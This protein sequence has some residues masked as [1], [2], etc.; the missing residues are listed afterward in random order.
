MTEAEPIVKALRIASF[1]LREEAI[2]LQNDALPRLAESTWSDWEDV[3]NL[4]PKWEEKVA[5]QKELKHGKV[6]LPV[7]YVAF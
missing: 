5:R 7:G 2:E 6:W 4:L 1:K 3:T